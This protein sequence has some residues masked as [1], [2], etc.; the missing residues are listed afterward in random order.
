MRTQ[1]ALG[2]IPGRFLFYLVFWAI[3]AVFGSVDIPVDYS[4]TDLRPT[5][6]AIMSYLQYYCHDYESKGRGF[7]SRRAH[8]K[9][10]PRSIEKSTAPGF[11]FVL[12]RLWKTPVDYPKNPRY[13]R[14]TTDMWQWGHLTE[15]MT[16]ASS[17]RSVD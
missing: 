3:L 11:F 10:K 12:A 17:S 4:T 9:E 13:Y 16:A 6:T 7:E 2:A 15:S 8:Q 1:H 5:K 14:P